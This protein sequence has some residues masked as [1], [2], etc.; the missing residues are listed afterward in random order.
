M[1]PAGCRA[2]LTAASKVRLNV[3]RAKQ[4]D[5]QTAV[6]PIGP[7]FHSGEV[8]GLAVCI[9]KPLIATVSADRTLRLWNFRDRCDPLC[10]AARI[11][12][13]SHR[14][15]AVLHTP[16][17]GRCSWHLVQT[18]KAA[19]DSMPAGAW[20]LPRHMMTTPA[21]CPSTP[22]ASMS[23]LALLTSFG[24]SLCWLKTSSAP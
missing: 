18:G 1:P 3:W 16:L 6:T 23:C 24:C 10:S 17:R 7:P 20:S 14:L 21:A 2:A 8:A 13:A 12:P 5:D 9:R 11:G 22:A 4:A 15:A 19:A